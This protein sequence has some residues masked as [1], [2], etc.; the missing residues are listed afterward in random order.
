MWKDAENFICKPEGKAKEN[1]VYEALETTQD[2][3]LQEL[4]SFLPKYGG[5][6]VRD[7]ENGK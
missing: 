2:P 4:Q 1:H 3:L 5:I 6:V 7:L